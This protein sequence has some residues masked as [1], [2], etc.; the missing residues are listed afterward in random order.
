[1]HIVQ[2]TSHGGSWHRLVTSRVWLS[3]VATDIAHLVFA[4]RI[5]SAEPSAQ[6]PPRLQWSGGLRQ[7]RGGGV[8]AP[9]PPEETTSCDLLR[10]ARLWRTQS[11]NEVLLHTSV[12]PV[13]IVSSVHWLYFIYLFSCYHELPKCVSVHHHKYLRAGVCGGLRPSYTLFV[14]AYPQLPG[15]WDFLWR[16]FW[17]SFWREVSV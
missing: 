6:A 15:F 7:S 1:M 16:D 5:N 12:P 17:R 2:A 10:H 14:T 8:A 13:G 9:C 3:D 11:G 4:R